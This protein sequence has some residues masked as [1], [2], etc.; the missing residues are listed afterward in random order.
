MRMRLLNYWRRGDP[1]SAL[2]MVEKTLDAMARGG[3]HDQLGGGVHRYST[4]A[5][6][7]VLHFE[8]MLYDQ[9]LI[10]EVHRHFLPNAAVLFRPPDGEGQ[11]LV[12]E[13]P[14]AENLVPVDGQATAYVCENY[15]CRR[16]V[17]TTEDLREILIPISERV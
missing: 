8:K 14:F 7:L 1:P 5:Q 16:P 6:W 10:R 17:T 11:A 12:Q 4:D 15:A 2:E 3:I 13:V 9:A